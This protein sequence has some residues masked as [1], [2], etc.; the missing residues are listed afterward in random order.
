MDFV[1]ISY[2][3]ATATNRIGVDEH[4]KAYLVWVHDRYHPYRDSKLSEMSDSDVL[5]K[6]GILQKL[7]K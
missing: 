1:R 6:L 2:M 3:L 5:A 4:C 7:R